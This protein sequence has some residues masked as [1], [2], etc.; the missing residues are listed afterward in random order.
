MAMTRRKLIAK[1][2][3]GKNSIDTVAYSKANMTD[4]QDMN[5][6][7]RCARAWDCMEQFRKE[8]ERN[9]RYMYGDQWGDMVCVNGKNMTEEE[10]II[11]QGNIPLKNNLIRRLAKT[12]I[13]TYRNQ[14]KTPVAIARDRDE[15]TLGET[16]S[17]ML[18]YNNT[19][20]DLGELNARAFEEFVISGLIVEKETYAIRENKRDCWTDYVNPNYF[21][22]D[23]QLVDPR[24]R[25]IDIIGELHDISFPQ[26][27]GYFAKSDKDIERLRSIYKRSRDRDALSGFANYND[28]FKKHRSELLSF[29]TPYDLNLCRVVQVWTLEQRKALWCHDWLEGEAYMDSYANKK[30]IDRENESRME[31]NRMKDE[32]GQYILDE[33]GNPQLYMPENEVPLIEYEYRI[34]SYWYYRFLSPFGDILEEG[35][36]P[37]NHKSHPYV[38]K[39]H[40]F[41]DGEIHSFV[42]DLIDQQRYINHYIILNDFIVKAGA[43]G[44]LVIDEASV[45][46]DMSIED[47]AEEWTRFNGVIKLKLKSGAKMPEQ[48]VNRQNSAG[49]NEMIQLQRSL[50]EDVS[51]VHGALQGKQVQS[52]TSGILYQ[53][54][55][56]NASTSIVDLMES[57]SSFVRGAMYKKMSNIQQFYDDKRI[58]KVSGRNSYVQWDPQTMGGVEFD[59]SISES[60]NTPVYRA[61]NNEFLMQLLSAKQIT[62]EQMLE[63][64]SFPFADHLLQLI[65]AQ[66]EEIRQQQAQLQQ[67]QGYMGV[68]RNV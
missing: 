38:V 15:Q 37:Y 27:A 2:K 4:K 25:D 54:Q 1:S 41:I 28:T 36:S 12:V 29:L 42:S 21:F 64:G 40:P 23:G 68:D 17:T 53:Q 44:V 11:S 55:A 59:L 48:I 26:L 7:L 49:I 18:E 51:G 67:T 45:P 62:I 32:F 20:N 35:E 65:Q 34:E 24:H 30:A 6:V 57:F 8:R 39:A 3:L 52:G 66:Q 31:D 50:M 13:G 60:Y 63:A 14:N 33:V 16:M 5:L 10:Y 22:M 43:K 46:E 56:N 47:I 58:I 9:K 19:L 61:I